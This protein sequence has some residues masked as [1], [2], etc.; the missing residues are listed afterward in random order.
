MTGLMTSRPLAGQRVLLKL[1]GATLQDP[2]VITRVARDVTAATEAG[3]SIAIV[4]GGGPAINE[5]LTRRGITWNFFEGQRI[6]TPEMMDV[7]ETVLCGHVNR[8]IV[9]ALNTSHVEALGFSG[10]DGRTLQ[11]RLS[12]ERMGLV[13]VVTKVDTSIFTSWMTE[14]KRVGVMAP[15]GW[16]GEGRALNVNADW[17]AAQVACSMKVNR[18]VYLTDQD[19]ILDQD[20]TLIPRA[21][22]SA[23]ERLIETGVV[24]GGMLAKVRTILFA[25]D[26]GVE[27]VQIA[28]ARKPQALLDVLTGKEIGTLC[29]STGVSNGAKK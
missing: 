2:D 14:P 25:L 24:A 12:D 20:K 4:H 5:E 22:A 26:H 17:A 29:V 11:C 21:T 8:K 19:G 3:A 16:G 23:L 28:N 15:V 7:I 6:T 10:V 13:G 18:L 9:R 27:G 1:G